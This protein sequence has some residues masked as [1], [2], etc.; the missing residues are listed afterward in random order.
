MTKKPKRNQITC[1]CPAYAFPHRQGGGKC[2]L[3]EHCELYDD[4]WCDDDCEFVDKCP[5]I[6]EI[7]L[8]V[9]WASVTETLTSQERNPNFRSWQ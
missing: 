3:P 1:N 9:A 4:D 7:R 6:Q 5:I 2:T 8:R